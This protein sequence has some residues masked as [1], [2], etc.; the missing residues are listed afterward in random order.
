[1]VV[2]VGWGGDDLWLLGLLFQQKKC[3][4]G[5]FEGF[6]GGFLSERKKKMQAE[7]W[8]GNEMSKPSIIQEA[9]FTFWFQCLY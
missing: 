7:A 4:E 2:V 6:P 3:L 9:L 1:M 8:I 5:K